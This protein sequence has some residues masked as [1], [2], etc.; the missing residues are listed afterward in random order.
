MTIIIILLVEYYCFVALKNATRR[1]KPQYIKWAKIS[2][3]ILN[4]LFW[5][6]ILTMPK[7]MNG[8]GIPLIDN[9]LVVMAM[10]GVFAKVLV[11]AL[12][13][14][15]DIFLLIKKLLTLNSARQKNSH[16]FIVRSRVYSIMSL[17]IGA[18]I[19]FLFLYGSSNKYNYVVNH[20]TLERSNVPERFDGLKI[21]QITD[22]HVGSFDNPALFQ[23]GLDLLMAQQPDII[24]FTGDIVNTR[25]EE[26]IPYVTQLSQLKAPMGVFAVLGNHDYGDYFKWNSEEEKKDNLDKLKALF[27]QMGWE[28][29]LNEHIVFDKYGS[30][31]ALIGVEN[32]SAHSSFPKYGQLDK[33]LAGL[34]DKQSEFNILMTHDPSHWRAEVLNADIPIDLTLSGH[35]HAMQFGI[36]LPFFKFSPIQFMYEEWIGLYQEGDKFLYVNPGMGFIGYKGRIGFL[37]EI[38]ILELKRK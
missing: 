12:M 14:L 13:L 9:Y 4:M 16:S 21:A 34:K 25:Y 22:L 20:V 8:V 31:L 32:W 1:L 10:G 26:L 11:G 15:G 7:Y 37:P 36:N 23:K 19:V 33:A 35:T 27:P 17:C 28:L 5:L 29:L 6:A 2:Y 24:L 30:R 38:T 3:W 18:F